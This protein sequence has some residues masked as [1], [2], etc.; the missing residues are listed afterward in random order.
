MPAKTVC[1]QTCKGVCTALDAAA[2]REKKSIEAY[3]DLRDQCTYPDIHILLAKLTEMHSETLRLID[4]TQNRMHEKFD[5]LDQ[6]R[7]SFDEG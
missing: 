5:V 6:V 7:E 3:R 2:I 1:R 4:E